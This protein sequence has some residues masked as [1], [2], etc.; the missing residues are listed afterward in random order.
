MSTSLL[1][2]LSSIVISS[3]GSLGCLVWDPSSLW[4]S[5]DGPQGPQGYQHFWGYR[6]ANI[7]GVTGVPGDHRD[8]EILTAAV[9]EDSKDLGYH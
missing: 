9:H 7:L 2:S 8:I 4:E 5:Q 3:P 1:K 6:D